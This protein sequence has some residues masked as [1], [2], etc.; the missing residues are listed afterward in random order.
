MKVLHIAVNDFMGA[1]MC[2][3]RINESLQKLGINSKMLVMLKHSDDQTVFQTGKYIYYLRA[4]IDRFLC[5]LG[6][7]I[8]DSSKCLKMSR[9]SATAYSLPVSWV[10]LSGHPLVKEADII[11]LHWINGF[12]DQ[13]SFF[14]K[15][16][17]PI[18]WTLHDENLFYGISHYQASVLKDN[19]LEKK[20]NDVKIESIKKI[21]KLGIVF[22]S[23]FFFDK[24][25]DNQRISNAYKSIIHN[26]VDYRKYKPL[27][28]NAAREEMGI[29]INDIFI[30]FI[31]YD[32]TEQRKGLDKLIKAVENLNRNNI[33]ILAIG[34]CDN[35]SGN[36]N[37]ITMGPINSPIEMSKV[38]SS[39]DIFAMPS[40][41]EAFAQTPIEAM[42]CGLPVVAF[43]VSGTKELIK[44]YNGII[45]DGFTVD[46]LARGIEKVLSKQYDNFVIR[47]DIKQH[48]SPEIIAENY[49]SFYKKLLY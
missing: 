36:P 12:I 49:L 41:Q 3:L 25:S 48:F 28:K 39:S 9:K 46:D 7:T 4:I 20:Y 6:L 21:N 44:E 18:V 1:G 16:N 23:E 19:P 17:K 34:K 13:P 31:A 5:I 37:V 8:T 24:Y 40:S 38:I 42:A 35:F 22:L 32:I 47:E 30:L 33:K 2:A 15:V 26:S 14:E 29:N 10:D 43:P 45:C 11:H 27:N